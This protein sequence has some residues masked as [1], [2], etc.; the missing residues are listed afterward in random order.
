[1]AQILFILLT[2]L[3][4]I[5]ILWLFLRKADLQLRYMRLQ[6]GVKAIAGEFLKFQWN[7][8]R[9]RNERWQA[10][11]L[12]PMLFP[13][14]LGEEREELLEIKRSVKRIHIGIY[15]MLILLILMGIYSEKVFV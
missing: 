1:M 10:F 3:I 5:A 6:Q 13:L 4:L 11:L 8:S 2:A 12:F 7:D 15:V 14:E 9:A